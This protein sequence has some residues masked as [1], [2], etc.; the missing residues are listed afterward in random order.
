[1]SGSLRYHNA[2]ICDHL[3]SQY[4]VGHMTPRVRNRVEA[5]RVVSPELDKAIIH[6][7]ESFSTIHNALPD[8]QPDAKTWSQIEQQL[9]DHAA[10]RE[11]KASIWRSLRFWRFT[12]VSASL[13]SIV[14]AVMLFVHPPERTEDNALVNSTPQYIAVM[15]PTANRKDI[16]F[17]VNLYQKTE[18]TPSRLFI[19]WAESQPR[20]IKTRMHL[21]AKDKDTGQFAY[22]GLEPNDNVTWDLQKTTWQAVSSS[23]ELFFTATK[24][25]PTTENTLFSGPCIQLGNWKQN[26]I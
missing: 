19:Q 5:L 15:S 1:M 6:W 18:K 11:E 4:V 2:V 26:L 17:V 10:P 20:A 23:S 8:K 9:F 21:W 22:I 3:A 7:S 14:L 25:R 16:R 24:V 13:A 12:G